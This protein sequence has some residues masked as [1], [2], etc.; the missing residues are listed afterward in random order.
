MSIVVAAV[1]NIAGLIVVDTRLCG[2]EADVPIGKM[3]PLPHIGAALAGR[4]SARILG[5]LAVEAAT[6]GMT[7]EALAETLPKLI[8]RYTA[9][10]ADDLRLLPNR[11]RRQ[12][13]FLL[14]WPNGA[15]RVALH[16]Y[17][18]QGP[19]ELVEHQVQR[20]DDLSGYVTAAPWLPEFG[21][22]PTLSDVSSIEGIV[23]IA[24]L[25]IAAMNLQW[26]PKSAGGDLVLARIERDGMVIQRL[27]FV[28]DEPIARRAAA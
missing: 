20:P 16:V 22:V 11:E 4:G 23:S 28:D 19:D 2:S 1:D 13:F 26:A 8:S 24:R 3:Y 9:L 15:D 25:Q 12:E 6:S 14:G 17:V 18:Q 7:F 27:G 21:P 10:V 5:M